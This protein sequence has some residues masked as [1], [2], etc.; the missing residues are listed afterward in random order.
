MSLSGQQ[1][2]W[3]QDSSD[4]LLRSPGPRLETADSQL[5]GM[6]EELGVGAGGFLNK[7]ELSLVCDHLGLQE[8]QSEVWTISTCGP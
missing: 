7:E 6:L 4:C 5:K 3:K 8:L 1:K 2:R